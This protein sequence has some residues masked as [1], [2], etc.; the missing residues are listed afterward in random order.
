M[1]GTPAIAAGYQASVLTTSK[2]QAGLTLG[3][4]GLR[5][6]AERAHQSR[7]ESCRV[8]PSYSVGLAS[9]ETDPAPETAPRP[10]QRDFGSME[11]STAP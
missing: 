1:V 6:A 10:P 4:E 7:S 3:P 8:G 2:P 11:P 9:P 5:K